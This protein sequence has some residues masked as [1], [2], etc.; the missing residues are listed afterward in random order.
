MGSGGATSTLNSIEAGAV[1]DIGAEYVE[2][3]RE[4]GE[5]A[6]YAVAERA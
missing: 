3:Y 5:Y 2:P 6:E 1:V 4:A